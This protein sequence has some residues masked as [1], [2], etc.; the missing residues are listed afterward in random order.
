MDGPVTDPRDVDLGSI[1]AVFAHPD[2]EAYLCGALMAVAVDAGRRVVCVTATRGELGFP[3][4]D[5]RSIAER[6]AVREAELDACLAV[7][8]VHEHQWLDYADGG[9]ID[10]PVGE[11]VA[12]LRAVIDDM[13]P[14]T[15]LTFGPDGGTYHDDHITISRWT[16]LACRTSDAAPRLLYQ[17]KTPEWNERFTAAF[18]IDEIMM[19]EGAEPAVTP[20]EDLAVWFSAEGELAERKAKALRCQVSQTTGLAE[21][22]GD[23]AYTDFVRDE[24]FRA[25]TPDDWPD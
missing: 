15:V 7:L 24:F 3:D 13:R 5:P 8:G 16:T 9:C 21:Q 20:A 19:V 17:T 4:D 14:D 12:R 2:D 23:E 6:K 25:P 22:L 18:D 10:V 1:L 11:P